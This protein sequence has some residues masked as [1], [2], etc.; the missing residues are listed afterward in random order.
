MG[1]GVWLAEKGYWRKAL[2]DPHPILFLILLLLLRGTE[3]FLPPH[4]L[5]HELRLLKTMNLNDLF[6]NK[7][8]CSKKT[9]IRRLRGKHHATKTCNS[10][11]IN[12]SLG[13]SGVSCLATARLVT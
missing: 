7:L 6:L 10:S 2:E 12:K 5:C 8:R 11:Q 9:G 13:I 4:F 3:P 1:Q